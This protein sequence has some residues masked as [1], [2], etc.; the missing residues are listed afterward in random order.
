MVAC[1]ERNDGN[2]EFHQIVDF[3]SS[4]TIHY[5]LTVS[6]TIY[7]YYIE[8]FWTTAKSQIVNNVKQIHAIVDGKAV[9][10]S[11]SL[12]RNDL[13]FDNED[14][15][16]CLTNDDIFENLTLM[17]SKSTGWNEFSTNLASAV[18]CLAKGQK[19]NFSQLIFDGM[20]KNLDPKRFLMYPRQSKGFSRTVSPLFDSMLV[21]NQ[22]PK[23]EGSAIPPEP[24]PTPSASQPNQIL[25]SP[26]TYQRQQPKHPNTYRRTK[27]GRNTKVPQPGGS[28]KKFGDE[29]VYIGEDDRVVRAATTASSLEAEQESGNITKTQPT[30]TLNEP[31]PQGTGLCSSPW[32]QDTLG[33]MQA[34]TR[35]EGVPNLS[36]DPPLLGGHTLGSGKDSMEHQ[37]ELTDNV[38]HS[39]HDLPLPGVNTPGSDE[40]SLELKELMDLITKLSQR[41]LALEQSKTA[42]DLVIKKLQKKVKRLQKAVRASTSGMKLFKIGTSRRKGLD[43]ENVSKQGRKSD[44]TKPMFKDSDFEELGNIMENVEGGSVA[45]RITTARDTLNT[46]SINV[47][48][49][50]SLKVSAAGPS[51][52]TAEDIFEDEMTTIYQQ[53]KLKKGKGKIVE[54]EPTPKNPRKAQIKL[55]EELAQRLFAEE[56]EQFEREERIAKERAAEQEA[57]NAELIEQMEDK[58][59][60]KEQQRIDDFV[61]MGSELEVQRLKRSGHEVSEKPSKRQKIEE[62]LS[63]GVEQSAKKVLSEEELKKLVVVSVE[64]V[65]IE[66]LQVKYPIIDWEVYS[67]DT[68]R[69]W[70]IIRVGNHTEAHHIFADM[71]MKFDK[72]DLVK[73]W[74]LVKERF[75]ATKPTNDRENQIVMKLYGSFKDYPLTRGLMAVMLVN[76]LQVDEPSEMANE[77]L[78]K[79][80]ILAN[81]PRQ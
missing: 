68:R 65:Y 52:S 50:R 35:S 25:P 61:L 64:E 5:A 11:E 60:K 26:S 14:G 56:Q 43:K 30:A 48:T 66:A 76:K 73:I 24:Q 36:S 44:K 20:L 57:K 79:I 40:G 67:E 46:A 31:S 32:H 16:T 3:L 63:S 80:F 78:R 75:S 74:D 7:A 18:K 13:L 33:G 72:E 37:F 23:G 17:G 9:V 28:P 19:F 70:R 4:S 49:T 22:A 54:P 21:Q 1:L 12:V 2:A 71:L 42:Q 10:I 55:D 38:P 15:I 41:V 8:Q 69:Y 6:P 45:E 59:Y 53:Y 77:L 58:L 81:R 62:T 27:R 47:N 29:A 39:P 34:Q 51:T